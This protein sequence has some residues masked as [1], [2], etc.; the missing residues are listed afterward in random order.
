[1]RV[2]HTNLFRIVFTFHGRLAGVTQ[3]GSCTRKIFYT[4]RVRFA[5]LCG[6]SSSFPNAISRKSLCSNRLIKLGCGL[7]FA[8][9]ALLFPSLHMR[10]E[11]AVTVAD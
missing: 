9:F 10:A 5:I 11:T 2:T 3:S 4:G 6:H 1:M 8:K 7:F